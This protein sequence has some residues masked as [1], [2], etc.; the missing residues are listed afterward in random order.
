ML[1]ELLPLVGGGVFGAVVKLFSMSMQNK[2][3]QHK[4]TMEAFSVRD[5]QIQHL[6]K[7]ATT[8]S[9]FAFTRRTIALAITAIIV[10]I[11]LVPYDQGINVITEVKTGGSYLFGLIDTT[12]TEQVWTTLKGL[13]ILPVVSTSFQ[14]IV[15]AYFGA[16][17]ASNK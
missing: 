11:A 10:V 7:T 8:N 6:N 17:I 4:Q 13:V 2:A 12:Q 1:M 9:G 15:G 16:S 5:Q 3:E 14:A